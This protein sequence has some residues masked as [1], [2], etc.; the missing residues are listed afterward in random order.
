VLESVTNSHSYT[1]EVEATLDHESVD[2]ELI[3]DMEYEDE[4]ERLSDPDW[5]DEEPDEDKALCKEFS[6]DYMTRAVNFYDEINPETGKRKRR[7]ET[8]KHHFRRIPHQK[9]LSRFRR[10]LEKH[11]TKKQKL[12]KVDDYVFD[13][14]ERAR[15]NALPVHDID[16]RRW[17]L[18]E[19]MDESS[20]NFVAS[21]HWLYNFKYKHNIISR[22]VTKV[23][24]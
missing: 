8:V 19:A 1:F 4:T 22:K 21:S 15:E 6:L 18:K 10:Y 2:G 3:N 7:W 17:A 23:T 14:F 9:Y 13:M 16:L 5:I 24:D 20:H 11:G 12:D